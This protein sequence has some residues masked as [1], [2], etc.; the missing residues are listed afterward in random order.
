MKAQRIMKISSIFEGRKYT[1]NFSM[2]IGLLINHSDDT[3]TDM[4]DA[5]EREKIIVSY[6]VVMSNKINKSNQLVQTNLQTEA[7][8]QNYINTYC[9]GGNGE[10]GDKFTIKAVYGFAPED[11]IQALPEPKDLQQTEIKF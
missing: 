3:Q 10:R 2:K 4:F 8:A 11:E 9:R 6:D 7:E 5:P 1:G